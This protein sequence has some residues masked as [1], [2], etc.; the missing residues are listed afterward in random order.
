MQPRIILDATTLVGELVQRLYVLSDPEEEPYCVL[1]EDL[2]CDG[3][4]DGGREAELQE[5][6]HD[7]GGDGELVR[8]RG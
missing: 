2:E 6:A 8:R 1:E 3:E 7:F 4:E 5:G